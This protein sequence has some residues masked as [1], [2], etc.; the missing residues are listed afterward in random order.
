MYTEMHIDTVLTVILKKLVKIE[1]DLV[2]SISFLNYD[3]IFLQ[4]IF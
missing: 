2:Q 4:T 1:V 3:G